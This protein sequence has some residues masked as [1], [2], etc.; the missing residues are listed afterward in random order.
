[1]ADDVDNIISK[2]EAALKKIVDDAKASTKKDDARR[3]QLVAQRDALNAQINEI[4]APL[5][6]QIVVKAR[7]ELMRLKAKHL[8]GPGR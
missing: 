4:D 1:M 2:H 8:I 7:N 6:D 5:R 3:A